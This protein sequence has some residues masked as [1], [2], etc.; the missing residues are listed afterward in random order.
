MLCD[1]TNSFGFHQRK[2][3]VHQNKIL[4]FNKFMSL[5]GYFLKLLVDSHPGNITLAVI[6]MLHINKGCHSY[7]KKLVQIRCRYRQKFEPLHK[8][9]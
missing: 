9:I 7:H 5:L 6:S 2:Q 4:G 8:R 3:G 1:K